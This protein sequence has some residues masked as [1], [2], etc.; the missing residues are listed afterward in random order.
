MIRIQMLTGPNAGLQTTHTETTL[1]FG[2]V[3]GNT[4]VIDTPVVSRQHGALVQ[5]EG[6]W[7]VQ[8]ASPNGTTVN[9]KLVNDKAPRPL[10]A[11]DE[12][13]V[14]KTKLFAVH[15]TPAPAAGESDEGTKVE[16]RKPM[17]GRAKMWIGIGAYMVVMLIVIVIMAMA[18]GK[19]KDV[20]R[21]GARL[22]PT[23]ISTEITQPLSRDLDDREAQ[24]HLQEARNW[25]ARPGSR[26]DALYQ[27]YRNYKLALAYSGKTTLDEDQIKFNATETELVNQVQ[28]EYRVAY[29]MLLNKQ[30]KAAEEKFRHLSQMYPDADSAIYKNAQ[31][32]IR[33]IIANRP[34]AKSFK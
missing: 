32:Q 24:R 15:F 2:R 16:R 7:Y 25:Y 19:K 34:K 29:E 23:A 26:A 10:K 11:G 20:I 13:G 8:N 1:S 30:Y 21:P 3:A 17:S 33:V 28:E 14:G 18:G 5:H 6:Q 9:G 12:V 22:A 4:I 27:A 31:E